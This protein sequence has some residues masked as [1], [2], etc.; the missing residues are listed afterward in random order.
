[1]QKKFALINEAFSVLSNKA[2]RS[3]YNKMLSS[4]KNIKNTFHD[5]FDVY[6]END[7]I[8]HT[9]KEVNLDSSMHEK[10]KMHTSQGL[11]GLG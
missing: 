6:D 4:R 3:Q 5:H 10:R 7:S 2:K 9:T 8:F 1:M 11:V